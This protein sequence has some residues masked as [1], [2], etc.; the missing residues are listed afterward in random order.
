MVR[1]SPCG[2]QAVWFTRA[3]VTT[4]FQYSMSFVLWSPSVICY[5]QTEN[6]DFFRLS[7]DLAWGREG[8]DFNS[9][10][11]WFGLASVCLFSFFNRT[12]KT[13]PPAPKNLASAACTDLL[14]KFLA[15]QVGCSSNKKCL[16][17]PDVCVCP[18]LGGE[19]YPQAETR[20]LPGLH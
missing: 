3:L 4:D 9:W 11:L 8:E 12:T 5:I 14:V 10:G 16:S 17:V 2:E 19:L 6:L 20:V 7:G 15:W 13:T 18:Q 1:E